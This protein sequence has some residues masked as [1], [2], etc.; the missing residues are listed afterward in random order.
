MVPSTPTLTPVPG[1]LTTLLAS[2]GTT[3]EYGAQTDSKTHTD[4]IKLS[5]SEIKAVTETLNG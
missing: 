4:K 2:S 5:I 3:H 1:D